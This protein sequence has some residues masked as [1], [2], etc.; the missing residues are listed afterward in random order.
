MTPTANA[1]IIASSVIIFL[2]VIYYIFS[3]YKKTLREAKSFERGLKLS[4]YRIHLPPSSEDMDSGSRD[5]RDIT[6]EFISKIQVMYNILAGSYKKPGFKS[7]IWGQRHISF[8]IVS[9]NGLV[10][11][12]AAVP[13]VFE[14]MLKQAI[15]SAYPSARLEEVKDVNFFS[16]VGKNAGTVGGE[17]SLKK[18]FEYPIA[19]FKELKS[20]SARTIL[21][22]LSS[23]T[24]EDGVGV[25]IMIRPAGEGWTF[26]ATEEVKKIKKKKKGLGIGSFI[27]A[28]WKAPGTSDSKPEDVQISALDQSKVEAIEEKTKYPGF[29]VLIRIVVSSS[30]SSQANT[31][32]NNVVSAFSVFDSPTYNGFKFNEVKDID[33][34]T[35]SYI[36]RFFPLKTK[37]NI[38][39]TIELAT[40]FH[41]PD[42]RSIPTSQVQR[43]SS[44][45]VDGPT[46]EMKEGLMLGVNEFRGV[47][48][49]IR[50]TTNDRRRHTYFI[51]QTGTGKSVLLRNL[52]YQDML[53]GRGFAF[54]DPHGDAIDEILSLVP[55][56]RVEDIVYFSP[57]DMDNPIGLNLFD[58]KTEDQKDFII[59]ETI[60]I[61]Y[62]LYDPNRQGFIGARFEQIF[63]NAALILM[64]GPDGGTFIDIPK[65]L[66]DNEF[67]K[68]RLQYIKD[69]PLIDYWTKEWPAAQKSNDAGEVTSWV[70]SK[71]GAFLS[72]TMMRNII[73]QTKST[74]DI[75]QIMDNKKILLVNLSKGL[76]GELNMRLLGMI[77]VM[78]FQAAAM[79]RADMDESLRED[80]SLYVDEFQNFATDSFESI[81]SEARKYRLNL[82]I[83]HQFMSQL[84]DKIRSAVLGNVGTIISGRIGIEDA[85]ILVK[86]FAPIFDAEDLTKLPNYQAITTV[87]ING[88]PSSPFSM[89]L[90]APMGNPNNQLR[91]AL[92][93]LS[94]TKY[95]K[96]RSIV[97]QEINQRLGVS[98]SDEQGTNNPNENPIDSNSANS[99]APNAQQA[100]TQANSFL[101]DWLKKRQ[102]K[103]EAPKVESNLNM[104]DKSTKI[105]ADSKDNVETSIAEDSKPTVKQSSDNAANT[106]FDGLH[107][108]NP[109]ANTNQEV[110]FKIR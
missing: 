43:Q 41:L 68:N 83:A 79:S 63:R 64:S 60:N 8:E 78:K 84:T 74:F 96:P 94:A 49:E 88:I 48:K 50:L 89:N 103:Q 92:K 40:L 42:E 57:S 95:G 93:K 37:K 31:L 1:I 17:F 91:D 55:K 98:K 107:V 35:S 2:G 82:I 46:A 51:G 54:I 70:A 29:E 10:E 16:E 33:S 108:N 4:I 5:E 62:S 38:L 65:T 81:M 27:S 61:L 104:T 109:D 56:E 36:F 75:R 72:N 23:A 12:F 87:M 11:Y 102:Q 9:H 52:A 47:K 22:A 105:I 26:A 73:G 80:F 30:N 59:Q 21:N 19:T 24:K 85:E 14:D 90:V 13:V 3:Q 20:D 44:K 34:L 28:F 45:Q 25:Q 6:E 71:F 18:D 7:R 32:L 76:V 15:A 99:L 86:K 77:F 110:A 66:I 69:Q 67:V 106:D 39:N 53:D 58:Y 100:N 97:E 101:D